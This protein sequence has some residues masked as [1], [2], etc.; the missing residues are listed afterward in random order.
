MEF[1][2]N[3]RLSTSTYVMGKIPWRDVP[4][5]LPSYQF[6]STC[7][8]SVI[9]SPWKRQHGKVSLSHPPQK[10]PP[11]VSDTMFEY[12]SLVYRCCHQPAFHYFTPPV[13]TAQHHP[14]FPN[15]DKGWLTFLNDISTCVSPLKLNLAIASPYSRIC[16]GGNFLGWAFSAGGS[17]WKIKGNREKKWEERGKIKNG[18]WMRFWAQ[19][20]FSVGRKELDAIPRCRCRER[21]PHGHGALLHTSSDQSVYK[22]KRYLP[23]A[24]EA[25][26]RE[27]I[28]TCQQVFQY[29]LRL[30]DSIFFWQKET[31]RGQKGTN[32]RR[33]S[34]NWKWEPELTRKSCDMNT[35]PQVFVGQM[36]TFKSTYPSPS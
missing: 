28:K 6:S 22:C 5:I 17:S 8:S 4:G 12:S 11:I 18:K 32:Y 2:T 14:R 24:E 23:S 25:P 16:T 34:Y 9:L 30:W 10:N 13:S 33:L 36:V 15:Q 31:L 21:C 35:F 3:G 26:Y 7:R 29:V 20:C 1:F 19:L 27:R